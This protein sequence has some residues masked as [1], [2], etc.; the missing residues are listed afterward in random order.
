MS[1]IMLYNPSS[2]KQGQMF[3]AIFR[4]AASLSVKI[5]KLWDWKDRSV[6]K[7]ALAENK[8]QFPGPVHNHQ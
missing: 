4:Y 2:Q 6:V 8:V 7:S 1:I 5:A 3:K